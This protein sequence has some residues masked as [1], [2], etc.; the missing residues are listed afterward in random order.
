MLADLGG[1]VIAGAV[2]QPG[3]ITI[4]VPIAPRTGFDTTVFGGFV[5][6]EMSREITLAGGVMWFSGPNRSGEFA[7]ATSSFNGKRLRMQADTA[8]GKFR[9]FSSGSVLAAAVDV[10]A[11]FQY[12]DDLAFQ[13]RYTKISRNFLSPKNGYRE[14]V[15]LRAAGVNWSPRKW[16]V[17]SL[18]GSTTTR[19]GELFSRGSYATAAVTITPSPGS[20]RFYISH[21][22]ASSQFAGSSAFTLITATKDFHRWRAFANATRVRA[23]HSTTMNLQLG[24][25]FLISDTSSLEVSQSVG[26]RGS[27]NGQAD[28]RM[29]GLFNGRLSFSAGARYSHAQNSS[30]EAFERVTASLNL[31]RQT[32]IQVSYTNGQQGGTLLLS[33][34]GSLF[35]KHNSNTLLGSSVSEANSFG[36]IRGRVYQDVDLNG[37]FDAG[38]DKPLADVKVMVDASRYIVTDA[39]G[40]Y[41][42]ETVTPGGHAVSLD[43]LSVRAD[44]TLL[45]GGQQNAALRPGKETSMDFRLVRTG[46]LHGRVWLDANANGKFDEGETPLADVRVVTEKGRDTLHG[47]GRFLHD[48]RP[49]PGRAQRHDRRT[50]ASRED[51]RSLRSTTIQV[52]PGRET[53]DVDLTVRERPAEVKHFER[54][55]NA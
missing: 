33:I 45:S 42:F 16:L 51:D 40:K 49:G 38:T 28:W 27:L 35:K 30:T 24:S 46:R 11:T 22:Q 10:T 25:N 52:Y 2:I 3:L 48:Q 21:S 1:R 37:V 55:Q 32:S 43:L 41:D 34:R 4:P 12:S 54:K 44:L 29:S 31:P 26:S 7:T 6:K 53:G 5:E 47:R 20:P 23:A 8:I 36:R 18:N 17:A 15:E 13:G 14:P 39:D 50:D 9:R 19:P